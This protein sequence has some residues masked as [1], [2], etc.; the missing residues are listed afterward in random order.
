MPAILNENQKVITVFQP[1]KKSNNCSKIVAINPQGKL[2]FHQITVIFGVNINWF[3]SIK[4]T[5]H[6]SEEG[7][8]LKLCKFL[9]GTFY[10][11]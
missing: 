4:K 8:V 1:L 3:I 9:D 10:L 11:F 2:L 7:N 5:N 6:S